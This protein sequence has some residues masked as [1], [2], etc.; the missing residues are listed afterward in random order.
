[1]TMILNSPD[2]L[3][4]LSVQNRA[5]ELPTADPSHNIARSTSIGA[6]NILDELNE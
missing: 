2:M 3:M 5:D 4:N 6:M 1:M